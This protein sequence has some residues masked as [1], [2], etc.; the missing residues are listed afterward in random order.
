M[1]IVFIFAAVAVAA[2]LFFIWYAK[3]KSHKTKADESSHLEDSSKA[4]S[5]EFLDSEEVKALKQSAA[6][7][8]SIS[9]EELDRMSVEEI[10]QLAKEKEL[11]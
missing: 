1:K 7:E 4:Y 9:I 11:I 2:N 6:A 8:L 10:T 5:K 3:R